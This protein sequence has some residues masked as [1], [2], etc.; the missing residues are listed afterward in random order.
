MGGHSAKLA[1]GGDAEDLA[2]R[3]TQGEGTPTNQ[4]LCY[5]WQHRGDACPPPPA[6]APV[7]YLVSPEPGDALD[8]WFSL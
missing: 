3:G 2:R 8:S 1:P 4:Y 7:S 5:R 6:K